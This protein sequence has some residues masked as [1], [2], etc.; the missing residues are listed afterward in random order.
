MRLRF[1]FGLAPLLLAAATATAELEQ[2]Y[3]WTK[4]KPPF[5]APLMTREE[6][7][8]YRKEIDALA[9]VA[10]K[11]V[12]WKAHVAAMQRRA[13]ERGVSVQQPVVLPEDVKVK[14]HRPPYFNE[15]MTEEE[16]DRYTE[17]YQACK[18]PA[19]KRAFIV[20][21]IRAMEQRSLAR[22][23]SAPDTSEWSDI[24]R[25]AVYDAVGAA[26]ERARTAA[27]AAEAAAADADA[28]GAPQPPAADDG[29]ES[30]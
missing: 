29:D 1:L 11:S 25:R 14:P 3:P 6:K 30:E 20:E 9:T 10:E 22:G 15:I 23:V 26:R 17:E 16:L 4:G 28:E 8:T 2:E 21:H 5:G 7:Q 18:T 12:Y 19:R 27:E 13:V 24:L